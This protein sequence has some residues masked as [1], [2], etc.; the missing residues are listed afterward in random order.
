MAGIIA[1]AE[2]EKGGGFGV[3]VDWVGFE[4]EETSWAP[5]KA[6]WERVPQF[7]TMELWKSG[8]DG[9]ERLRLQ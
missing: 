1:V 6:I 9:L 7:V 8:L 3:K 4:K 2:T 5:L